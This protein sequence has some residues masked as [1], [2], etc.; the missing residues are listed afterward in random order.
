MII[1]RRDLIKG[2]LGAGMAM[3]M[4]PLFT[5]CSG[6]TRND[7][8]ALKKTSQD[9]MQ[10]DDTTRII[11]YHASLAPSGHNS[12]PWCVHID[13]PGAWR[14]TIDESRQ[15]PAVDPSNRE[16][17]LSMGAFIEN[18]SL[19]AG[20]LGPLRRCQRGRTPDQ[21]PG[22]RFTSHCIKT[23]PTATPFTAFETDG[24]SNTAN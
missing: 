15:L 4:G 5:S 23:N 8:P 24:P 20:S 17:L 16:L 12:Q 11:L 7:L 9:T 10:L 3:G 14:V 6:V 13:G 21:T 22:P 19:A 18:L 1:N 2:S